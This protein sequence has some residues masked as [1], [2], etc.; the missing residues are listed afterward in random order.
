[1]L[2]LWIFLNYTDILAT[3]I[4]KSVSRIIWA[5]QATVPSNM[6]SSIYAT[7]KTLL[8]YLQHRIWATEAMILCTTQHLM[9]LNDGIKSLHNS[10]WTTQFFTRQ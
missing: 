4:P 9:V 3:M 6:A 5:F 7:Q 1:M 2:K 8:K 10:I